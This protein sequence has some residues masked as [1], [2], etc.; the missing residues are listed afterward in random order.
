MFAAFSYYGKLAM[1]KTH[2]VK[3]PVTRPKLEF[4]VVYEAPISPD[5]YARAPNHHFFRGTPKASWYGRSMRGILLLKC[6]ASVQLI[7]H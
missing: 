2:N 4:T 1:L 5:E 3:T 6:T 7:Q